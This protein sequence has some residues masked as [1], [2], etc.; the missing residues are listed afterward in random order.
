MRDWGQEEKGTGRQ[1]MRWLDGITHSI[2]MSLS[3]LKVCYA[4]GDGQGRLA[5]CSP[6]GCKE[7]DTTERLNW[8]ELTQQAL[9]PALEHTDP[10]PFSPTTTFFGYKS[11]DYATQKTKLHEENVWCWTG[12][13]TDMHPPTNTGLLIHSTNVFWIPLC[14]R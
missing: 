3:K 8:I 14:A 2:D 6:W 9:P 1:R 7:S 10:R 12:R 5:C 13:Q 4:V 11:G